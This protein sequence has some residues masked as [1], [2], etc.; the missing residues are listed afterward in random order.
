VFSVEVPRG[1][2]EASPRSA[3]KDRQP[4]PGTPCGT[5]LIV[6]D[7]PDIREML[8]LLFE[9]EGYH[10]ASVSD[11]VKALALVERGTS[12]P[13]LIVA[14]YNLPQDINGLELIA[15]LQTAIGPG[16]R[17]IVLTG[18]ISTARLLEIARYD[19]LH[20][21]KPIAAHELLR[22]SRNLLAQAPASRPPPTVHSTHAP[23][24]VIDDDQDLRETLR[25]VLQAEGYAVAMFA[26]GDAFFQAHRPGDCGCLLV[27]ARM[28]GMSG[29]EVVAKLR[30]LDSA[31]SAIV[32]TGNGAVSLAVEAMKMGAVDFIEKP[33]RSEELLAS[34][35]RAL[36]LAAGPIAATV[37]HDA[38]AARVSSL[39][40]R[41]KQI[42]GLVL[43]GHPSKNIAAD[44]GISQRTVEN[45]R[46]AIMRK[47]G[48][49]SLPDL[50]RTALAAA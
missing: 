16:L 7:D 15:R 31:I 4:E 38:A 21:N 41:Q 28:P 29:L 33:V 44:L 9:G 50:V 12:S 37:L 42:M 22:L 19:C 23:I 32:I 47:T 45:H 8:Q 2:G 6:E 46:A 43:A 36:A 27:D 10:T 20:V 17:G 40:A 18:D 1:K 34:V 25:E 13:D 30:S 39:T 49:N 3:H 24:Y 26:S 11:A 35:A 5:V 48:S 14:D